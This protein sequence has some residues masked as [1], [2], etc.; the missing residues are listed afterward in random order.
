MLQSIKVFIKVS[1]DLPGIHQGIYLPQG[2]LYAAKHQVYLY[3]NVNYRV[4]FY[5]TI[6][7]L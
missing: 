4:Y 1:C 7:T 6:Y 5:S 2:T 3:Y